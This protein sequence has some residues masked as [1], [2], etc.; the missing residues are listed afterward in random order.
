MKI[1]YSVGIYSRVSREDR[2]KVESDSIA[3]QKK[4]CMDYLKSHSDMRLYDIY[5]DDG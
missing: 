3:N 2:D 4:M 1:K 5:E